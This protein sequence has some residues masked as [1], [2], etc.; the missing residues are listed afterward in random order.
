[1]ADLRTLR[2]AALLIAV[3]SPFDAWAQADATARPLI[4]ASAVPLQAIA[5]IAK[6]KHRGHGYLRKPPSG[7]RFP[8]V[9]IIHGGNV[10]LPDASLEDYTLNAPLPSRFLAAGYVIAVTTYRSRDTDPQ[11]TAAIEDSL[12]ALDSLRGLPYVDPQ[13]IVAYGCSN[14]GD[15]ALEVARATDVAAIAAEEPATMMFTG[16]FNKDSPKAGERFTPRDSFP[17]MENPLNFYTAEYQRLTQEKVRSINVPILILQGDGVGARYNN[18]VFIPELKRAGKTV[19]LKTYRG[20]PHC[21]M[22]GSI[23][24]IPTTTPRPAVAEQAFRDVDAFFRQHMKTQPAPM[25]T[26]VAWRAEQ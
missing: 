11:S 13:S 2:V 4:S 6:D 18:D 1:M 5:P 3:L 22:F 26:D 10:E 19:T 7:S 25:T 9:L 24:N 14:G 15:L 17:I 23:G 8:A 12:A 20:E 21:F 16:V